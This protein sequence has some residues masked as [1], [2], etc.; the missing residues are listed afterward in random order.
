MSLEM[1]KINTFNLQHFCPTKP[2]NRV[3]VNKTEF[4]WVHLTVYSF[5]IFRTKFAEHSFDGGSVLP[6]TLR[7]GINKIVNSFEEKNDIL[8]DRIFRTFSILLDRIL[9]SNYKLK[10]ISSLHCRICFSLSNECSMDSLC[11]TLTAQYKQMHRSLKISTCYLLIFL[12]DYLLDH[13]GSIKGVFL[14][15]TC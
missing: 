1:Q 11:Q 5:T 15:T 12:N 14:R 10:D 6:T 3:M 9:L 4:C 8:I 7:R 2:R 13:E